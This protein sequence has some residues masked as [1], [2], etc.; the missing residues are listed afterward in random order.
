MIDTCVDNYKLFKKAGK[1][2]EAKFMKEKIRQ[3]MLS[4]E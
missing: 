4:K 3:T 1:I 2:E